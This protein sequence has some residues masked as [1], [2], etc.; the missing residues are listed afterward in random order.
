[1]SFRDFVPYASP[2]GGNAHTLFYR[3]GALTTNSVED[4]HWLEGEYLIIDPAVGDIDV[5]VDNSN[6]PETGLGGIAAASSEALIA[7]YGAT[8]GAATFTI[9]VPVYDI[10]GGT[11]FSTQHIFNNSDT[12]LGPTSGG[13]D[14]T[15]TG[16]FVGVTAD[17]WVDDSTT[18]AH[19]HGLDI[20]TNYFTITRLLDA[21]GHDTFVSGN[22]VERIVFRRNI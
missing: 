20:N 1:M 17:I 15:L 13:G 12:D 16:V 5:A 8:S 10:Y 2:H 22:A 18:A 14:G 9:G 7:K 11:E 4:T 6:D 3:M 21:Q 19:V